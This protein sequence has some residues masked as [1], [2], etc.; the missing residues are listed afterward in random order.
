[1]DLGYSEEYGVD[2]HFIRRAHRQA[3][4]IVEL[5]TFAG[6]LG[7]LGQ[8]T[9]QEQVDLLA[10]TLAGF[11]QARQQAE[12]LVSNWRKGDLVAMDKLIGAWFAD[13]PSLQR[14]QEVL[15]FERNKS[16][17]AR[18]RALLYQGRRPFVVVGAGHLIGE[19]SVV[20]LLRQRGYQVERL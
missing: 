10:E 16:M 19:G 11:E 5:E 8:L 13:R 2:M 20:D 3:M 17:A 1:V 9:E 12:D 18:T 15:L 6:Q 4:D 14:V 7:L